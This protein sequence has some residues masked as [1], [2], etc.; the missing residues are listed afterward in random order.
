MLGTVYFGSV[1]LSSCIYETITCGFSWRR[2]RTNRQLHHPHLRM[3]D[4]TLH[5]LGKHRGY[6]L[7]DCRQQG[8]RCPIMPSAT[9]EVAEARARFLELLARARA[10]EGI[11][12]T[13]DGE[14]HARLLPPARR[15]KRETAPLGRLSLPDDLFGG[16]DPEQAAIDVGEMTGDI[17]PSAVPGES[18]LEGADAASF[19]AVSIYGR[20]QGRASACEPATPKTAG[21][22][23]V[24]RHRGAT[25][26]SRKRRLRGRIVTVDGMRTRRGRSLRRAVTTRWHRKATGG[27]RTKT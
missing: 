19:S 1:R 17:R 11:V 16:D 10:G 8:Y 3:T 9:Y 7:A 23:Q 21:G 22:P 26:F 12:I 18:I 4:L 13:K 25:N 27:H 2:F 24:Q 6:D 20:T 15:G 5:S 14:P